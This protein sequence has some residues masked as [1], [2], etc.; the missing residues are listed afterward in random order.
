MIKLLGNMPATL[1]NRQPMKIKMVLD[2]TI[3]CD[4][5]KDIDIFYNT[6]IAK[7]T[8]TNTIAIVFKSLITV[9][10]AGPAV[11]L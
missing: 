6:I 11:S 3:Y 2:N 8:G 9:F 1:P 4:S 5:L 10:N 7:N